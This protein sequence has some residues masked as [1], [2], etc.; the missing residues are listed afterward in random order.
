MLPSVPLRKVDKTDGLIRE[1]NELLV[2]IST[3]LL[4]YEI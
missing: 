3:P 4:L 2:S 1:I